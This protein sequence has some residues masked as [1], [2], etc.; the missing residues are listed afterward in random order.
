MKKITIFNSDVKLLEGKCGTWRVTTDP[1]QR[2][3]EGES[4]CGGP[5]RSRCVAWQ[6]VA[7]GLCPRSQ[8]IDRGSLDLGVSISGGTPKWIVYNGKSN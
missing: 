8:V 2:P 1:S 7:R 3:S 5:E 4:G 6:V